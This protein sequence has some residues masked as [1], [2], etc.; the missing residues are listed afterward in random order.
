MGKDEKTISLL[1]RDGST[2]EA[3]F[4]SR[5]NLKVDRQVSCARPIRPGLC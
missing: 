4:V 5:V 1:V 2:K 3:M